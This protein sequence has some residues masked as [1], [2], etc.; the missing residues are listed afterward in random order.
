VDFAER[1]IRLPARRTK[2][3]RRLD[4]P[5]TTIVRDVLIARRALGND[6][7][8]CFAADSR[9]GHVEEPRSAFEEIAKTTGIAVSPHDL[10]RTFCTIAESTDISPLALKALVNHSIGADV[11]SGYIQ[12]TCE[13]LRGPAQR[14][15]DRLA[16]LCAIEPPE[17]VA[18]IG[19]R[20]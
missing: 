18:R 5:M 6:G 11:T 9:S 16:E 13:R 15:C 17:G 8:W 1:A 20:G 2:A 4:L 10:R 12:M 19:D 14:V 3:G 7:G